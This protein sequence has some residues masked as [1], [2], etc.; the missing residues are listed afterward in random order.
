MS[1][2]DVVLDT[3]VLIAGLRSR[4]GAS[5]RLLSLL[6]RRPEI[7]IHL[8]VPLVLEYEAVAKR[9][10]KELGLS[11][12]DIED[13]LDFLCSIAVRH[14]IFFLWRPVLRDPRD[15]M[16]LELAVAAGCESIVSY[17]RRDFK[18][19]ERFGIQVESAGEFLERI[20]EMR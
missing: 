9:Q 7:Q 15:D 11:V 1:S 20:G 12:Q 17:N 3:N 4:R 16:V 6:G 14:E 8:S 13:V 19:A 5:Y 18:A 10:A 2:H